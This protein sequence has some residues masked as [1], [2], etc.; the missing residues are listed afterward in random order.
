[1]QPIRVWKRLAIFLIVLGSC[2]CVH[3]VAIDV[4]ASKKASDTISWQDPYI[5]Q[6]PKPPPP[7]VAKAQPKPPTKPVLLEPPPNMAQQHQ[8]LER[9]QRKISRINKKL[10]RIEKRLVED[11]KRKNPR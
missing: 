1:M 7:V 5:V 3:Y 9:E 11:Q 8:M 2:F 6:A 10:Q 4:N